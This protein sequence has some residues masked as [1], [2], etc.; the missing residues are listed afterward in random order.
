MQQQTPRFVVLFKDALD[1]IKNCRMF[2]GVPRHY[3]RRAY[4][5][6]CTSWSRVCGRG[7]G[8][9]SC[10]PNLM[11]QGCTRTKQTFWTEV[12]F[13]VTASSGNR[14]RDLRVAKCNSEIVVRELEKDKPDKWGCVQTHELWSP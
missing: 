9:N 14:D 8:S 3:V 12:E 4:S 11:V 2:L 5:C 6:W 13:T 1:E 7:H 10:G